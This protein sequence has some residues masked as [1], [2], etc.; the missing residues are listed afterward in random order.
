MI[1]SEGAVGGIGDAAYWHGYALEANVD[2]SLNYRISVLVVEC[3][4][5]ANITGINP[6]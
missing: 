1:T 4:I 3:D 6:H 2:K 5:S